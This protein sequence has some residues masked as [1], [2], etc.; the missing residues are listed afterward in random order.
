M[1]GIKA[2]PAGRVGIDGIGMGIN[3]REGWLDSVAHSRHWQACSIVTGVRIHARVSASS[4]GHAMGV[5]RMGMRA[6]VVA[7]LLA[8]WPAASLHAEG[9][10]PSVVAHYPGLPWQ[11]RSELECLVED[12]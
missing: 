6:I 7:L 4:K 2:S 5:T 9:S 10:R 3:V 8:V 11:L 12:Y 1:A